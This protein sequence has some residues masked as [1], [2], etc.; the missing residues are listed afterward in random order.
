MPALNFFVS[1]PHV[2]LPIQAGLPFLLLIPNR[3]GTFSNRGIQSEHRWRT[4][5]SGCCRWPDAFYTVNLLTLYLQA[6]NPLRFFSVKL[7]TPSSDWY[8]ACTYRLQ[9]GI[10]LSPIHKNNSAGRLLTSL[11]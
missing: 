5:T 10:S 4:S 1:V 8:G 9:V 2:G 3:N 6:A 11:A 7:G